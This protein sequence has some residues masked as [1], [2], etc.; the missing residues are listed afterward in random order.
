LSIPLAVALLAMA[1]GK[2]MIIVAALLVSGIAFLSTIGLPSN[3]TNRDLSPNLVVRYAFTEKELEGLSQINKL[4]ADVV[5]YIG[6]DPLYRNLIM[7]NTT[8]TGTVDSLEKSLVS[9][10]FTKIRDDVI[11]LRNSLE[12][13][14]FGFGSG[15]IYKLD[16]RIT[17]VPESQG[18]TKI[19]SNEEVHLLQRIKQ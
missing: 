19:W 18:Y 5:A 7:A 1:K 14:P 4:D 2:T 12:R 15:T 6:A 11:V 8:Y 17:E 13:E 10:D 3:N 16:P 9:G